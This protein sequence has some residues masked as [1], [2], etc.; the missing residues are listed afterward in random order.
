LTYTDFLGSLIVIGFVIEA[1]LIGYRYVNELA[2]KPSSWPNETTSQFGQF[3]GLEGASLAE[4]LNLVF[5]G[6]R[7]KVTHTFIYYPFIVSGWIVFENSTIV[8]P[9]AADRAVLITEF[10]G[11]L[12]ALI[13]ALMLRGAAEKARDIAIG[14]LTDD[15]SREKGARNPRPS[16]Q[17]VLLLDRVQ[18]YQEGAFMPLS[19]QPLVKAFLW[20]AGSYGLT[21][22]LP[23]LTAL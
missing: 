20:P 14:R 19:Q 10:I 5:I 21:A 13:S 1:F 16:R 4:W 12:S 2:A 18:N 3:L 22:L 11:L 7:T 23:F 17:L 9:Y 8:F 6:L 15:L